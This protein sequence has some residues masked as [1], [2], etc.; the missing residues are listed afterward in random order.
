MERWLLGASGRG[1][2]TRSNKLD[3]LTI[4][5]SRVVGK[6]FICER[7]HFRNVLPTRWPEEIAEMEFSTEET[8]SLL[9]AW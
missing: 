7:N 2:R 6:K 3:A 1:L 9:A 8:I 5:H 4:I